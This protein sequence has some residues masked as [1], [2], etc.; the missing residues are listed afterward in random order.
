MYYQRALCKLLQDCFQLLKAV[1]S[2]AFQEEAGLKKI[3]D[4]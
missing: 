2:R 4:Y 1:A 3:K